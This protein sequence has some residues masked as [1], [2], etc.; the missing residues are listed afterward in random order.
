MMG[1]KNGQSELKNLVQQVIDTHG[2]DDA[3]RELC[4]IGIAVSRAEGRRLV[5]HA[6]IKAGDKKVR[7]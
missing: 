3:P 4:R 7:H 1:K 2:Y 6:K 5:R